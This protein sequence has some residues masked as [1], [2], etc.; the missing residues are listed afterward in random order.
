LTVAQA[1]GAPLCVGGEDDGDSISG[2]EQHVDG[3]SGV[4]RG[5]SA[6]RSGRRYRQG[7]AVIDVAGFVADLK[8]QA[9]DYGFHVHDERHFVE[10]YSLRQLWEVD[11]HPEEACAG[12]IDLHL[13]LDVDPRALLGFED[14][15]MKMEDL[16]D[17]PPRG[18]SFP[19]LFTWTLP[20]LKYPPDLLVLATDIAGVGGLDLPV[21]VSA[22]DSFPSVTDAPERSLSIVARIGLDLS[23]VY[24]TND[25]SV[26]QALDRCK[27]V[28]LY[29]LERADAW[30]DDEDEID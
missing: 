30:L 24:M 21:E 23:D 9:I 17:E 2:A 12:P 26:A 19:L 13:S 14:E 5:H 3:P 20:P 7:V 22:I 27:H 10:T 11:L 15:V 4:G 6:D 16:D 29:L 28:S 1:G 25:A 8:S 18:F